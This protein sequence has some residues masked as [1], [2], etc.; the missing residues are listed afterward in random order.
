MTPTAPVP[1]SVQDYH[2][3]SRSLSAGLGIMLLSLSCAAPQV[4]DSGP[5]DVTVELDVYSGRPNPVW[6]LS[7]A[8]SRELAERLDGLSE[9]SGAELPEPTLGYRG[10]WI[11]NPG[12]D[13]GVPERVYV[14][15]GGLIRVFED[16]DSGPILRDEAG[17]ESWLISIARREGYDVFP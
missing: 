13:G 1:F 8:D 6:T 10:F 5:S 17:L 3:R 14:S 4:P 15:R 12:G 7:P 11:R 2:M 16:D 9:L